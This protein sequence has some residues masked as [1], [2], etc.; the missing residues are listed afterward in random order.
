MYE[1]ASTLLQGHQAISPGQSPG[2]TAGAGRMDSRLAGEGGTAGRAAEAAVQS[3]SQVAQDPVGWGVQSVCPSSGG[4]GSLSELRAEK[5]HG[6]PGV[7]ESP[8]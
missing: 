6:Q 8:C 4:H 7:L 2:S 5:A 3:G 1:E